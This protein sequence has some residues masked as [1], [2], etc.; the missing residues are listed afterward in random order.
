MIL[1][2]TQ[3]AG[4]FIVDLDPH[5][6]ERGSFARIFD[7]AGFRTHGLDPSIVEAS[8][9][10]NARR[11]TMRGLHFQFPP[12]A[13]TKYVRCTRGALF[14]VIVDL[15]PESHTYLQHVAVELTA[16]NG[17]GLYCPRRFAHGYQTLEDDTEAMYLMG[18]PYA[19]ADG[20][21][22]RHDDRR[23]AIAWPLAVTAISG[24]D[25]SWPPLSEVEREV[26]RRMALESVRR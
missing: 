18:D 6:D 7:A 21:G 12:S 11:G 19:P 26:R 20:G 25:D 16:E 5:R 1:T 2:E 3:L 9:A 4:A 22:L 23:L 15:R 24:R 14:D 17:R 8:V 13:E 10:S